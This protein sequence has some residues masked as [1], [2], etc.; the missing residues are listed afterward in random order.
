MDVLSDV[1]RVVRLSGAVFFTADFSSPWAVESPMP[2]M[3]ASA[4]LPEAECVVLFHILVEGDCE[5]D[6][7]DHPITTM[8]SGDV[9]VFLRADQH[10]MRSHHHRGTCAI[11]PLTSIFAPGTHDEPPLLSHGGG[12][13][14]SRFVCGY[15][16]CD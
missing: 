5:V 14:T 9:V 13:S 8:E 15:L 3:L 16:N 4:V 10:T 1:L 12:G 11:T 2:H 6:C 7:L